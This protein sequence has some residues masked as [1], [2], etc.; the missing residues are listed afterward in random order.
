[1]FYSTSIFEK[2]AKLNE[3]QAFGATIGMNVVNVLMTI[4]STLMVD[5]A[6]RRTLLLIGL[7]GMWVSTILFVVSLSLVVSLKI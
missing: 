1:M 6:G 4:V 2:D 5:K 3:K 7:I